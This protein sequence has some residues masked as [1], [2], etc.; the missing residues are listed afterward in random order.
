MGRV[1]TCLCVLIAAPAF[2][3]VQ[4][5]SILVKA[6]DDQGAVMPGVSVTISSPVLVTG[7]QAG[8]TDAGGVYRFPSLPPST[9]YTIRLELQGFQTQVREGVVVSVGQTTPIDVGMKVGSLSES[10]TVTG[11]SPVIDTTSA[12]VNVHLDAKLLETTPS[13]RDIWSLIEYKVPGVVMSTPDVGGNQGGLQRG[14]SAR[15]TSN[16]QNTQMLNGVN[17]GD[18]AAIG[19]AGYYY[20]PS[21]F[22]DIQIQS[23]AQD[24]SVPTSGVFINM[25]TKSGTN[26][27]SG[28]TLVTYQGE[29]TQWDNIDDTLKHQG[30]R[31]NANAVKFITNAN[32]NVGGPLRKNKL[33][34][35]GSFNDQRT[36]V[37]VVG[38]PAAVWTGAS[39]LDYTDIT[40]VFADATYQ[41]TTNNRFTGTVSR[42]LYNKP[43][44][45]ASNLN[46][47]DSTAHE[48]DILA[49]YQGLW[50]WVVNQRM[51]AN[52]SVS[53]NSIDFPLNLK[54]ANQALTDL[55][56][57]IVTRART[58]QAVMLRK[59]LEVMSNWQYFVPEFA[60]GR[61]ELR[62]G[63]VNAYTPEDQNTTRNDDLTVSYRSLPSGSTPAGAA[64]V[65]LF[66]TPLFQKR[67]VMSTSLYAQD[68]YSIKRLTLV[69]GI[70]WERVEGWVPA[71]SSPSSRWFPEGTVIPLASGT[72]YT[73]KRT[74]DEVR[75]IPL[76]HHAGP[77]FN[78]IYDVA[79]NGKTAVKGTIARYYDQIGTGTPNGLN[80]NGSISQNFAWNDRNNDLVFQPGELGTASAPTVP[81]TLDTLKLARDENFRRPYRNEVTLGVDH[82]LMPSLRLSAAFIHRREYDQI[83]NNVEIAIPFD[84]YNPVQMTEPGRDGRLGTADDT[85]MTVYAERLPLIT[86][87]TQQKNDDRIA[88]RYD[89]I[90]FSVSKRY[91]NRW[92]MIGGYTYS[93]TEQDCCTN[94][95][96]NITSPNSLINAAGKNSENRNQNFKLT[97]SYL[98]PFDVLVGGNVR[99]QSGQPTT[100]TFAFSGLPQN[101][102]GTQTINVEP[103]GG[104]LLPKLFTADLRLGKIFRFGGQQFEADLDFY[105]ITNANTVFGVRRATGLINVR[106]AGDPSGAI[107]QISQFLS[108]TDV[109]GP[110]IIRFN[111]V[112]RFGGSNAG[113]T[114]DRDKP[115]Q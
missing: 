28:A 68:S 12:N 25:V 8:V 81:P 112:Y 57:N 7:S 86:S 5:G 115:V 77:R 63:V 66:N 40:S 9:T 71:Q 76:W 61:H 94:D 15:G 108:P 109:L 36:H 44:R 92:T 111:V 60:G 85:T 96:N 64:Q 19:F 56:T 30:L 114:L 17:V 65:T 75:N 42:Q 84:Y 58:S 23:G 79:G 37:N 91:S 103:R 21:A 11:Q 22:E 38:F 107:N 70:R 27:V 1:L 16:S 78:A 45:G 95:S 2:A 105:N 39:E 110:R 54:T 99:L 46:T 88:Q 74:F 59:R 52:S 33:F 43:N 90:E 72:T 31:P 113:A 6:L 83:S 32:F 13:G 98:L 14:L 89:G 62:W 35:F 48:R 101:G 97:G 3:Q 87:Q 4:T 41:P 18:P 29:G 73:V 82:E 106:E 69:G 51:F 100:R 93:H 20:D 24:I 26:R 104:V 47:P 10:V 49:V 34:Y 67:A 80:P 102:T 53:F 55:T 50:N